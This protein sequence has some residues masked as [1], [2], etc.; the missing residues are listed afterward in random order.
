MLFF[1][2]SSG[3][4]PAP[5]YS[6]QPVTFTGRSFR[7][8]RVAR[9]VLDEVPKRD[10][11]SVPIPRS[12]P[13]RV[14]PKAIARRLSVNAKRPARPGTL[15]IGIA[16]LP[17]QHACRNALTEANPNAS[18][19]AADPISCPYR[20]ANLASSSA[21]SSVVCWK[22]RFIRTHLKVTMFAILRH[23]AC[24]AR[25]IIGKDVFRY[26]LTP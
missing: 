17:L 16:I 24:E 3:C 15:N 7:V 6:F 21:T 11:V 12:V 2:G 22:S 1:G 25:Q 5:A 20:A 26:R 18:A 8:L 10:R 4:N 13:T 23:L 9:F 19:N 14:A